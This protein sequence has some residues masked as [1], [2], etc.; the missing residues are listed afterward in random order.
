MN[1]N[2]EKEVEKA[3]KGME[4][5]QEESRMF[6]AAKMLNRKDSKTLLC[7]TKMESMYRILKKFTKLKKTTSN[8]NRSETSHLETQHQ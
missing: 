5:L 1:V 2:T 8:V 3:V 6:K 4:R 7:M